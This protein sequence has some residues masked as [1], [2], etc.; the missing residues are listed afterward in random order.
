[1]VIVY[2][3]PYNILTTLDQPFL[4]VNWTFFLNKTND[5]KGLQNLL[6]SFYTAYIEKQW[7]THLSVHFHRHVQHEQKILVTQKDKVK[8]LRNKNH[9]FA[10]VWQFPSFYRLKLIKLLILNKYIFVVTVLVFWESDIVIDN[11]LTLLTTFPVFL[12]LCF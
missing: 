6:Y 5:Q 2:T 3:F 11:S 12:M 9:L 10:V 4:F 7:L 1:M 8:R